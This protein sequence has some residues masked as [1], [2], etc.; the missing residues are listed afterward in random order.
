MEA[1]GGGHLSGPSA[2]IGAMSEAPSRPPRGPSVPPGGVEIFERDMTATFAADVTLDAAQARL[3]AAGQWLPVDGDPRR[4]IGDLV[5]HNSTGPLRLGYGAWRDLLLGCQFTNAR[6]ELITAGGRAIKNVAGYDLTKLMVGQQGMLGEIVT[7]TTRTHRLPSARLAAWFPPMVNRLNEL[8]P[9]ACRPQWSVLTES[10]MVC[11]YLGD[12]AMI[13]F[14]AAE[15]SRFN[16][17]R[18]E[19]GGGDEARAA[20]SRTYESGV[21]FRASVPPNRI[22]EFVAV[23]EIGQWAADPAFGIVRGSVPEESLGPLRQRAA[24]LGGGAWRERGESPDALG[25]GLDL[26]RLI[27]RLRGAFGK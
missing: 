24:F 8:L 19:K 17:T 14:I 18:I 2:M 9:T 13:D 23:L 12:E 11:G 25:L 26:R 21:T 6:G 22:G 7:I 10:E 16:P 15:I 27:D 1:T 20:F 3:R 4:T 5:A